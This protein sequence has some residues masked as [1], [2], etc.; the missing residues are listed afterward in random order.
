MP[1]KILICL[2]FYLLIIILKCIDVY[3]QCNVHNLQ[4][5]DQKKITMKNVIQTLKCISNSETQKSINIQAAPKNIYTI[6]HESSKSE[7]S[8][9][10]INKKNN[11]LI[12]E[13]NIQIKFEILNST[14]SGESISP[15][16][17][18]TNEHGIVTTTLTAGQMPSNDKGLL[19]KASVLNNTSVN[20]EFISVFVTDAP[21]SSNVSINI[22]TKIIKSNN[23]YQLPIIIKTHSE[24]MMVS[25]TC[26]L[27]K[28]YTGHWNVNQNNKCFPNFD[29]ENLFKDNDY[30]NFFLSQIEFPEIITT[31][32]LGFYE[33]LIKYPKL[34]SP[35]I[36]CKF[37][38]IICI[39]GDISENSYIFKL[40]YI[41]EES[42]NLQDSPF[43]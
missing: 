23:H 2:T 41:E 14:K 27:L 11:T 8:A 16:I 35:W 6:P 43:N 9:F 24:E 4:K 3:S 37:N 20:A 21:I 15:S 31:N 25:V 26:N 13:S 1:K 40:P 18:S 7:I 34:F 30:M 32:N 29:K 28:Y 36:I 38:A 42:C 22:G 10:I 19:I 12:E 33:F 5:V 17:C 39:E